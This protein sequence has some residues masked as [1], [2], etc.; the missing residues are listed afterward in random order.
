MKQFFFFV[1]LVIA[2]TQALAQ[3][4]YRIEIDVKGFEGDTAYLGY[5]YG[6]K[7]YIQD[8]VVRS[9]AKTF[10]FEGEEALKGGLYL[11]VMPPNNDFVQ[12]VVDA[13]EQRYR[14]TCEKDK[15]VQTIK[16]DKAPDNDL[17]YNYLRYLEGQRIKAEPLQK[18]MQEEGL[19]EDKKKEIG[20]QLEKVSAEVLAYQENIIQKHPQS[21]T[22]MVIKS[23]IDP[24]IPQFEGEKADFKRWQ[25]AKNHWFD[26]I[27]LK[28]DRMLRSPVLFQKVD[29]YINKL[30]TQIPDSINKSL[31][32]VL[33][34]MDK[35][36]EN[37]KYF[38]IHYLNE[39][40]KS[41]I[42][43]MDAVYVHLV[44]NY[45]AKGLAPWT[46]EEQ[47]NKMVKN[48]NTLKPILI[49]KIAPD[50][51]AFKQDETPLSLHELDADYTVLFFWDPDCGHCKK[52]MPKMLSFYEDYKEKGVE[53]FAVCT[54]VYTKDGDETKMC[55]ETIEEK[56]MNK[57]I[58]VTD[59]FLRS[60]YKQKYDIRSTPQ[61]Y[62][63]DK[64]KEILVKRVGA[65]DLPKIMDQIIEQDQ[66]KLSGDSK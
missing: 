23:A 35:E 54:R 52:S 51:K 26:N 25:W 27:N 60:K 56:K 58:N 24:E 16:F 11:F 38:L 3:E 47:L 5:H 17:F 9:A 29:H 59:K 66:Q 45:Y 8:T 30:T 41:K 28:D 43:G 49:G 62:V 48:S 34:S 12:I 1:I 7:Q 18:Q 21:V 20:A 39:Y 2:G 65:E 46:E 37:F 42:V 10:V 32:R 61:I 50:I 64:K 53:V 15:A 36:S 6:N 22:G 13:E 44:D 31:D 4:G 14:M 33:L 57:W 19:A 63:L 55:W 40:A